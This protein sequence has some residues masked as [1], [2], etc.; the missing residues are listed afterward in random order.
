MRRT[1]PIYRLTVLPCYPPTS[2]VTAWTQ[3]IARPML[4]PFSPF[5]RPQCRICIPTI[6]CELVE[7]ATRHF[8]AI[9]PLA[10]GDGHLVSRDFQRSARPTQ[11]GGPLDLS[12]ASVDESLPIANEPA[13][14]QTCSIP[15]DVILRVPAA[16]S[17]P[18]TNAL[19]AHEVSSPVRRM[20]DARTPNVISDA[21]P[22]AA[23]R[24]VHR[25]R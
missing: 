25:A 8:S 7:R 21:A 11:G 14:T 24:Q 3:R 10:L 17:L 18:C 1:Q 12:S 9:D 16:R 4:Q 13:G 15:C 6:A 23:R 20:E 22:P 19:A 2:G 5:H